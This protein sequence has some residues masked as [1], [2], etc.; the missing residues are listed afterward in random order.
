M[1]PTR[2]FVTSLSLDTT[3][4]PALSPSAAGRA[5][6]ATAENTR[7]RAAP[8]CAILFPV[9]PSF[10]DERE[11][12]KEEEQEEEDDLL[13]VPRRSGKLGIRTSGKIGIRCLRIR[14]WFTLLD[15][16]YTA[17]L[18]DTSMLGNI[19]RSYAISAGW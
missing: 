8:H 12:E 17:L 5:T 1:L 6:R 2:Q 15:L 9:V 3:L 11:E 13:E 4:A 19:P 16:L 7:E 18:S 10:R 14:S